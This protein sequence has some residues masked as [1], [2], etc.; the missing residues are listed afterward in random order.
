[1][2]SIFPSIS[3]SRDAP[4]S[5][6]CQARAPRRVAAK[7]SSAR[8]LQRRQ[9]LI[10]AE[11][12][13]QHIT[14]PVLL[15]LHQGMGRVVAEA[16]HQDDVRIRLGLPQGVVHLVA[17]HVGQANVGEHRVIAA[18]LGERDRFLAV[19][20]RLDDA[21]EPAEDGVGRLAHA[22]VIVHDENALAR[23]G[24]APRRW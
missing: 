15:R 18:Q 5:A 17:P 4:R 8:V 9:Q 2:R 13:V 12:L 10:D 23:F 16:G 19:A 21:A 24:T 7:R 3:F 20:G 11:R 6:G 22:F 1:M 14:Q